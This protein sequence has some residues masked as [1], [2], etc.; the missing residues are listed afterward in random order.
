MGEEEE[1]EEEKK[2]R[3]GRGKE[4]KEWG[5]S[6]KEEVHNHGLYSG[7]GEWNTLFRGLGEMVMRPESCSPCLIVRQSSM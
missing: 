4:K 6:M 1:K 5:R 3:G 7:S 2:K